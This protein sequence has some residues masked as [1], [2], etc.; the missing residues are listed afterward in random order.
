METSSQRG[1]NKV[2]L[3]RDQGGPRSEQCGNTN[4]RKDSGCSAVVTRSWNLPYVVQRI[5]EASVAESD[6]KE[7]RRWSEQSKRSD[8][9]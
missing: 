5:K 6:L 2:T 3:D 7:S 9:K 8:R 1:F 4:W